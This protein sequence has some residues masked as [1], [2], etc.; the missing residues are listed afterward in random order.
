[1]ISLSPT[2]IHWPV[3]N[4]IQ[5]YARL[6]EV[7]PTE[8]PILDIDHYL[9]N[10]GQA[11]AE[12]A[13]VETLCPSL[14]CAEYYPQF[15]KDIRQTAKQHGVLAPRDSIFMH[16]NGMM[17]DGNFRYHW[18]RW[19]GVE[20]IPINLNYLLCN[21]SEMWREVYPY[22]GIN[23]AGKRPTIFTPPRHID[24]T[25]GVDNW[26]EL[27]ARDFLKHIIQPGP[28]PPEFNLSYEDCR[29]RLEA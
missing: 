16:P 1:M 22:D 14:N 3:R 19:A 23:M 11:G 25:L 4:H 8:G 13:G 6:S 17:G 10:F 20:F 9:R 26:W 21:N 27:E 18:L 12:R 5:L 15:L 29:A 28:P 24:H 2:R 7:I